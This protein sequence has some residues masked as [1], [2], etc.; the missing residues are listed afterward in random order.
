MKHALYK[1]EKGD[2][3]ATG[4]GITRHCKAERGMTLLEV[5]IA[6]AIFS[7]GIMAIASL[8]V[9]STNGDTRARL[10]TEAAN[11]AHDVAERLLTMTYDPDPAM[12]VQEFDTTDTTF[13]TGREDTIGRYT[14]D[15]IVEPHSDIPNALRITVQTRWEYFGNE[16]VYELEF[17]KIAQ[18]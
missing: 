9:N 5:V 11:V 15:W 4:N 7:I 17:V 8:Q 14:Y 1:K 12:T 10:A 13:P 16:K 3:E 6:L 2:M 18:I